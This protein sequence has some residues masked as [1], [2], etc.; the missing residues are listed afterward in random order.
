MDRLDT[1]RI[2]THVVELRS[3]TR[4]AVNLGLPRSTVSDAVRRLEACLGVRL[5]QRTTRHVRPTPDGEAHYQRC[6]AIL[7]DVEEAENAFSGAQP[8][9]MVRVEM[10]G[11]LAR[12][13]ILPQL[14][15]FLTRYPQIHVH[16]SEGDRWVDPVREGMDCVL[17][18]GALPDSDMVARRVTL[19]EETTL[20]AP[21]YLAHHGTPRLPDDLA[22]GHEMVGF[23]S[24]ATG[25]VLPL[26]FTVQG[27]IRTISL[28]NRLTVTAAE[29]YIAAAEQGLGL[30]QIPRYHAHDALEQGRLTQVLADYPPSPTP[31]FLLHPRGRQL[32]PRVRIFMDWVSQQFASQA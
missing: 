23:H 26:E 5:L 16:L 29:S 20:A 14:P 1:M 25:G 4:A 10:Q 7:A 24:T 30:I 2:F 28:P 32:S 31:V 8:K 3:F 11:S 22:D 6:L 19:L 15:A 21:L 12:F 27:E 18:V 13:F 17:R 9:G